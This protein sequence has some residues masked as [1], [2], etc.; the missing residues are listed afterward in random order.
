MESLFD[1]KE[2]NKEKP[3]EKMD[4]LEERIN[5]MIKMIKVLKEENIS[6][7]QRVVELEDDL[8]KKMAELERVKHE[9]VE[10]ERTKDDLRYLT[11]ERDLIRMRIEGI[12]RE[13][14]SVELS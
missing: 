10:I 2:M 14:E 12:L 3:T 9:V 8:A 5:R 7:N 4:L 13:L 11:E 1:L 6:L